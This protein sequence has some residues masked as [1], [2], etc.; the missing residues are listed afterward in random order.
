MARMS[1]QAA[2]DQARQWLES[3]DLDRAIG[4]SEH[5]LQS[6]P[7]NL[8]AHRLLGEASLANR[9]LDHAQESF[10]YILAADPENIP[11]HVGLGVTLERRGKLEQ[12]VREFEQALE[13]K[14]DMPELRSQV[15]RL[16]T[17]GG[18]E[19][20]Q[21][22]LSHAGLARLYAKGQ[23]L[24]Q[25]VN[26]FR[27]VIK[28]QPD[29]Y[30]ARV[31]LAETLWNNEQEEEATALS[32]A[33]ISE[34]PNLIKPHLLLGYMQ[35]ASG[36]HEGEQHWNKA[37]SFD[38]YMTIAQSIFEVLP[39]T[40]QSNLDLD[41]WD[42][43]AWRK[44]RAEE[45]EQIAATRP[46]EVAQTPV[47]NEFLPG[48]GFFDRTE[49]RATINPDESDDFLASLLSLDEPP[50]ASPDIV[51][52]NKALDTLATQPASVIPP[53]V[54]PDAELDISSMQPFS[55]SDL[56]LSDD[57]LAGLDS[58]DSA[59]PAVQPATIAPEASQ[60]I[61]TVSEDF[62][63]LDTLDSFDDDLPQ[64]SLPGEEITPSAA[65]TAS[66]DQN[67]EDSNDLD[68]EHVRPFTFSEFGL[69]DDEIASLQSLETIDDN[70]S[71][72][73]KFP[74]LND[75]EEDDFSDLA[76]DL[77]PFSMDEIE[78]S[79]NIPGDFR[80]LPASLQAFSL[81]E[82]TTAG[83]PR[84]SGLTPDTNM[85]DSINDDDSE[86]GGRGFSWQQ[87]PLKAEPDFVSSLRETDPPP[88]SSL[89][90]KLQQQRQS[91]PTQ[92]PILTP[93][94]TTIGENEHLGL[95]SLDNESLRDDEV[96]ERP[97]ETP[98]TGIAQREGTART[99]AEITPIAPVTPP[100][101]PPAEEGKLQGAIDAGDIQPFSLA[102]LGLSEEEIAALGIDNP[103]SSSS[104]LNASTQTDLSSEPDSQTE[105]PEL[106][107]EEVDQNT[108]N[109]DAFFNVDSLDFSEDDLPDFDFGTAPLETNSSAAASPTPHAEPVE[110]DNLEDA[111][112]SGLI[113]PFSFADLGLS[114]EE[115][116]MLN[117]GESAESAK[118]QITESQAV[119]D[120][121]L[122][123]LE[124]PSLDLGESAESAEAQITESQAVNDLDLPDVELPSL[125]LGEPAATAAPHD[126]MPTESFT[127]DDLGLA[128]DQLPS[129][130]LGEPAAT[131][132]PHDDM[133]TESFT[134]DDL[135]LADDQLPSLDLGETPVAQESVHAEPESH[136][137]EPVG[138]IDTLEEAM[139]SGLIKP[140]SFAD[141]G[142]SDEEI[143]MLTMGEEAKAVDTPEAEIAQPSADVENIAAEDHQ[144]LA[145][146]L[147][148]GELPSTEDDAQLSD[149][150]IAELNLDNPVS[151]NDQ[152]L[153]GLDFGLED[154]LQPFSLSD[155]GSDEQPAF[156]PASTKLGLSDNELSGLDLSDT[157]STQS[158]TVSEGSGD[159]AADRL[160]ALGRQR[161]F[162]DISDIIAAVSNP[163]EEADRIEMI[164]Q[165]LHSNNIEIRD[166]DEVID[167]DAE[168]EEDEEQDQAFVSAEPV[169]AE[170]PDM[171]PF[172]LA[173]LGLSD[174]EIAMLGLGE[175]TQETITDKTD[176]L[177]IDQAEQLNLDDVTFLD[178]VEDEQALENDFP[179]LDLDSAELHDSITEPIEAL[180]PTPTLDLAEPETKP[181]PHDDDIETF[182]L[183]D[184][185]IV[186]DDPSV[187]Q[188]LV[189]EAEQPALIVSR[190][191]DSTTVPAEVSPS[192]VAASDQSL[193]LL[194]QYLA[195]VEQEP[196]NHALRL[197]VARA[198]IR[199]GN[200]D[201]GVRNYKQLIK[202]NAFLEDIVDDLV[203]MIADNDDIHT[204]RQLH[205]TL[206]DVF[207][208]QGKLIE[209]MQLY[210]WTADQPKYNQ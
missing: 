178:I 14:P 171:T 124:L 206:G 68:L 157:S 116:A 17:E 160:L 159:I 147:D 108:A 172:S 71:V 46:M 85:D 73:V 7:N 140:F 97:K 34:R 134:L 90:H 136:K 66:T 118:A 162:I 186:S 155:F 16:Y 165:L 30:D 204:L 23:M 174:D 154:D 58:L 86:A 152:D 205:R 202:R 113:K 187:T 198:G 63:A 179:V 69:D 185:D 120:L 77:Q 72:D 191:S 24:P 183:S 53:A 144:T 82:P 49:P 80:E 93:D 188:K 60:T 129:L 112:D 149:T 42:E 102:D 190:T 189:Q 28:N 20:P 180:S 57:E 117:M 51:A 99:P 21:L 106:S 141:L 132:A 137:F 194:E 163:E 170:S 156:N 210:S 197:S 173:E 45:Q 193:R 96:I 88:G 119:N 122:P 199:L 192:Q 138:E 84:V 209:A 39:T 9:Q 133:P 168:Y 10:E 38:P 32:R 128:D 62:Q 127:L 195:R 1:L 83:R 48:V 4:L 61:N 169:S 2:F 35:L 59:A 13:I 33:L 166:G 181:D 176:T 19:N 76:A 44:R 121:D 11:A 142:L 131:A 111:L 164:G 64:F 74:L 104:D 107:E 5:I 115:I 70:A 92:E 75:E 56:G 65:S 87:P 110:I 54:E 143:A 41:T 89:F 208:A 95:F 37:A 36:E 94:A 109:D 100:S 52:D 153:E 123:D 196:E 81:D 8:E 6:Y 150:K 167:M 182:S 145:E 47:Q 125:D 55:L 29:R 15:L 158:G 27:K 79:G 151:S 31:A 130:D 200:I 201:V 184:L 207:S 98:F 103:P 177:D 26:E 67:D 50:A 22:R 146:I 175:G 25:A 161:G 139:D 3:N 126:D 18:I 203:D 91:A 135:G 105:Q 12:A 43:T 148:L 101:Q 40:E 78:Q 114:D